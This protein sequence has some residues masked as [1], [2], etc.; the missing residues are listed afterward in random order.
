ML[1]ISL[2]INELYRTFGK[3]A[4]L[5]EMI[6]DLFAGGYLPLLRPSMLS[7]LQRLILDFQASLVHILSR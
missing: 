2:H 4:I 7:A 6:V 5:E 3:E 1:P